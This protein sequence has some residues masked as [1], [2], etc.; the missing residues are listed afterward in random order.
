MTC[1]DVDA[2]LA[3]YRALL[4][5]WTMAVAGFSNDDSDALFRQLEDGQD[6]LAQIALDHPEKGYSIDM[7]INS[8]SRTWA[9]FA[10]ER[11]PRPA[12]RHT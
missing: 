5:A 7:L 8:R 1:Q 11:V 9:G 10:S 4:K 2:Y 3:S 6:Q 12:N